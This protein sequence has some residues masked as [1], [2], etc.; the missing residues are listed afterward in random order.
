[1][2]AALHPGLPKSLA[3]ASTDLQDQ[4]GA[5]LSSYANLINQAGP[6]GPK[7][8]NDPIWRTVRLEPWEAV[9][10]D[11]PLFQR[12]RRIRQLGLVG[13][14]FPGAGYSRFEHSIGVLCQTQRVIDSI[15]RNS[16]AF[17]TRKGLPPDLPIPRFE[18]TRLRLTALLHDVG[19]GFMSHVSERAIQRSLR[20]NGQNLAGL[21][22]DASDFFVCP[23]PPALAEVLS[24]L[25]VLLPEFREVLSSARIPDWEDTRDLAVGMARIIAGGRDATRPFL[26]EILSGS[27][28]ADKLDYMPRDCYMAGLPMPVDVDRL[29]EKILVA[30]IPASQLTP[31]YRERFHLGEDEFVRVL[32][33]HSTATRAFEELVVS[34]ALLF[35][36]LYHHQ[37]ARALE[38]MVTNAI[39]LLTKKAGPFTKISTYLR[40]ADDEF[41]LGNWPQTKYT[42]ASAR[43]RELVRDVVKRQSFVRVLAFGPSLVEDDSKWRDLAFLVEDKGR[44]ELRKQVTARAKEYLSKGGQPGLAQDL[45]ESSLLI[46]LPDVQGIVAN[47]HFFVSDDQ[48]GVRL[49]GEGHEARRWTEAYE[50]QNTL[51]YI[52]CP[53]AYSVAVHLAFRD[54]VHE[55]TGVTFKPESWSLAKQSA[56]ELGDFSKRLLSE[57]IRTL[58]FPIPAAQDQI[59]RLRNT[60]K[61][62]LKLL[63]KYSSDIEQLEHRFRTYKSS[64]NRVASRVEIKDWLLQFPHADIPI[65]V[66]TLAAINFWDRAALADALRHGVQELTREAHPLSI[67]VF[68]IGGATTSAHHLTYLWDDIRQRVG[69]GITVLNSMNELTPDVPLLLYDDNVGSGGQSATVLMQWFA[70]DR[71]RWS[72]KEEHVQ[73]L[74]PNIAECMKSCDVSICYV[75]GKRTG[76]QR[77]LDTAQGLLGQRPRGLVISPTDLSCFDAAARVYATSDNGERARALFDAF[78][79]RALED[80]REEK[81]TEWVERNAL[82]YGNAGGLTVFFYNTPT[83]TITALWKE[84]EVLQSRCKALFPRRSRLH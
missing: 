29:L 70:V 43:A 42:A 66:Q 53:R 81:S 13:Y 20:V 82:G 77:V 12:L 56:R 30:E 1:M 49:Y 34:R 14:V 67:Q 6:K 40:L 48:L 76:L 47:T 72:V 68:G 80:R 63:E 50:F 36:K 35:Q 65:A 21:R 33:L 11:S 8:V 84:N 28:D 71:N 5:E 19:H 7:V 16:L 45:D 25:L 22:Y 57:H 17:S 10:V 2:R 83:T 39:E 31:E 24:G 69:T 23:K 52:Y 18:E 15:N 62:K 51:G 27:L 79:R 9:I 32:A 73:S 61:S 78:G 74:H 4:F 54:I 44:S 59:T 46:D 55:L 37:K 75:T 64:T 41:L 60:E 26:T 3:L 38:G 58:P